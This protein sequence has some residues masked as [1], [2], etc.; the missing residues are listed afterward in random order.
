MDVTDLVLLWVSV[1]VCRHEAVHVFDLLQVVVATPELVAVFVQLGLGLTLGVAV[2]VPECV[3]ESIDVAELVTVAVQLELGL[4]LRVVWVS[5][6][7]VVHVVCGDMEVD[8]VSVSD[9]VLLT[10]TVWLL[11]Q[12]LVWLLVQEGVTENV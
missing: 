6:G 3:L 2:R 11:S 12:V 4:E 7:E 5:V 8:L 1:C 9:L 10:V